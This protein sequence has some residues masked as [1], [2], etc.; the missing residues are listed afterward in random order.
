[1]RKPLTGRGVLLWL[2]GFFGVIFAANAYF[3]TVSVKT[4]RGEDEQ[5]PYLQGIEY[6]D[7]LARRAEQKRIGWRAAISA[8]RLTSGQVRISV[9]LTQ[10][11]GSPEA[12]TALHG[13]LRHPA[14]ENKDRDLALKEIQPG[15]YQTELKDVSPGSWDVLV[16]NTDKA[17]PF[18]A[19]RRL[20]VP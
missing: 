4:F 11:G 16:S 13:E 1:M 2:C 15:L 6:N 20:W 14:D 12:N 19:V 5:K 17:T 10:A 7:T 9:A 3:I 18:E 8:A